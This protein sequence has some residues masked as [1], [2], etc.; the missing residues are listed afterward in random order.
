[1]PFVDRI[2]YGKDAGSVTVRAMLQPLAALYGMAVST[3]NRLYDAWRLRITP[4]ALATISV[5]NLTVGG[6][7]KTPF[8]AWLAARLSISA[9][10]A[11]VLRGYRGGD[12]SM[13]HQRLNP[14]VPVIVTS[15]RAAGIETARGLG[16]DVVVLDDAFQHR[17]VDRTADIVLVSAEQMMRPRHLLPAGPWREPLSSARRADLLV[18]TRKSATESEARRVIAEL[19]RITQVPVASV[20]LWA[21]ELVSVTSSE[22]RPIERIR[23]VPVLAIAAIGEPDAFRSMLEAHG[24]RVTLASYRDHHP[25]TDAD[26]AA[27]AARASA[28]GIAVCT[29]KDAVKLAPRWPGHSRLWYVSQQL[30]VEQG[31]EDIDHLLRRV[32]KARSSTAITAG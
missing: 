24:A 18:V 17:Q 16:A 11:I 26:V 1:M 21:S 3:R 8:A 6:T 25:Y 2:W 9:R 23:G 19:Q 31:A 10:P 27:L 28:H 4:S 15:D 22:T 20:H 7:G 5:G 13:V 12:E 14:D 30:V 32:L 29:L